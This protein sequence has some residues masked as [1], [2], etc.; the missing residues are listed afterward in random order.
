VKFILYGGEKGTLPKNIRIFNKVGDAY[1]HLIDVAYVADFKNNIE[2][3]VSAAIYCNKDGILN[4]NQ[5]DYDSVG[6]PFLKN[7]GRVLYDLELSR[8]KNIQPDLSPLIFN[9]D[10]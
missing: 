5:Y 9:Y 8:K 4:D 6:F 7:I 10:K 2:F 3:F 1:G